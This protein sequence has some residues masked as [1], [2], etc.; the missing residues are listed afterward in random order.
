MNA[1]NQIEA[2]DAVR[3]QFPFLVDPEEK[4]DGVLMVRLSVGDTTAVAWRDVCVA[5]G[6]ECAIPGL[7]QK[8]V[9]EGKV[10]VPKSADWMGDIIQKAHEDV[11]QQR[12]NNGQPPH[13]FSKPALKAVTK[14]SSSKDY[15]PLTDD[16]IS[17]IRRLKT[18][19]LS[20][21][22]IAAQIKPTVK[23]WRV[24]DACA[25]VRRTVDPELVNRTDRAPYDGTHLRAEVIVNAPTMTKAEYDQKYG[26]AGKKAFAE[27]T[28]A[29]WRK[30]EALPVGSVMILPVKE[31]ET[32]TAARSRYSGTLNRCRTEFKAKF[33]IRILARELLRHV[34]LWKE[35]LQ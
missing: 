13:Q 25:A 1:V 18:E 2:I 33:R 27:S 17:E 28:I 31:K 12:K 8:C 30:L 22:Q 14:R 5:C 4:F 32:T 6:D 3:E 29:I 10:L 24:V 23:L 11:N 26:P 19:G 9:S 34:V 21:K 35:S 15:T 7:C 16:Q 20:I